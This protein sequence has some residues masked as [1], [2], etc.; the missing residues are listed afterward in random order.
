MAETQTFSQNDMSAWEPSTSP[1]LHTA[2]DLLFEIPC[3]YCNNSI[4][5]SMLSEHQATCDENPLV[6]QERRRHGRQGTR[7][8]GEDRGVHRKG[9]GSVEGT[10]GVCTNV[11]VYVYVCTNMFVYVYVCISSYCACVHMYIQ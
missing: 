5:A 9:G 8:N 3:E 10:E 11:F 7:D 6:K 1:P 4:A 2:Q